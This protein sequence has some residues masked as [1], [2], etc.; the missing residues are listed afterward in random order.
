VCEA[1]PDCLQYM[2]AG[3]KCSTSTDIGLGS[4]VKRSCVEYP[5]VSRVSACGGWMRVSLEV[6]FSP[7]V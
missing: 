4:E 7:V 1:R 3:G 6:R 2:C 5:I